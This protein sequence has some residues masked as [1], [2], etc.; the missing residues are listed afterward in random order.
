MIKKIFNWPEIQAFY[1]T[2]NSSGKTAKQFGMSGKTLFLAAKRG[3][4]VTRSRSEAATVGSTTRP[5][6]SQV[7]K[8]KLSK[9]ASDREFGGK[10]YRKTFPYKGVVLESSYELALA[11]ELDGEGI[12]WVRPKRFYWT[13]DTG[14]RRHYTPDFFLPDYGIYLDPKNDY[15]I[16]I[17]SDKIN[18]VM[19]QNDIRVLVLSKS[20]LSWSYIA[21]VV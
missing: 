3:D 15:L 17:D 10:N 8:D 19:L 6:H 14:R 12:A 7:T 16:K 21:S 18:R 13:D 1:D 11:Q 5:P 4:F 20:Q 9:I 2:G